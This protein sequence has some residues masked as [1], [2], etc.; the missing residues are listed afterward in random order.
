GKAALPMAQAAAETLGNHLAAAIV[1][2]KTDSRQRTA[3]RRQISGVSDQPSG[4]SSQASAVSGRPSAISKPQSAIRNRRSTIA[5]PHSQI[6]PAA[7]PVPDERNLRAARAVSELLAGLQADDLL[8]CLISGGGSALLTAPADGIALADLQKLTRQLLACGATIEEINTLRKHLSRLK[9]GRLAQQAAP[10][11][12]EALILSDVVGS[13]PDAIAS[14]PCAPDPTTYAD[15]LAVLR[16]YHLLEDTPPAILSH[17]Q[18]GQAGEFPE[19][20]KADDPLF[21]RVH[22]TIIAENLTAARAARAQAEAEGFH[23]LVLTTF[24]QG[25]ARTVGPLLAALARQSLRSGD[26]LP[27]P[28]CLICGGETTVTLHGDG[29]GGR[30]QEVALSAV[31]PL[32]GLNALLVTLAS[33][34]EDGPTDAAGAVVSGETLRRAR[35]HHLD[36]ADFLTRNDAYRFFHA[37]GDLLRTGP[38][39]TNVNDLNFVFTFPDTAGASL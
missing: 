33:D 9:G 32:N 14:G 6:I 38:T 10:A 15:A 34:G 24:L 39:Q 20:P 17:L 31:Q 28:A 37:L 8:L 29:L 7:H 35:Q 11:R 4:A 36:P 30:N 19:T 18:R 27:P 25:E 1:I 3:V 21:A 26:P 12:V 2:P 5:N 23:A 13:P 16:R 22:N